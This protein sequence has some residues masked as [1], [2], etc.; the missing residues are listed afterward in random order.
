MWFA[1]TQATSAEACGTC[2][3]KE[4]Q[5]VMARVGSDLFSVG[6]EELDRLAAQCGVVDG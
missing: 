1:R 6:Q 5:G 4:L 2:T 3:M